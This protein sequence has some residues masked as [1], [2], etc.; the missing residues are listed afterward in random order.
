MS[1][2]RLSDLYA[3]A[4]ALVGAGE[5]SRRTSARTS[6]VGAMR[7]I[8]LVPEFGRVAVGQLHTFDNA[9]FRRSTRDAL[10]GSGIQRFILGL[11]VS[12]NHDDGKT[13]EAHFQ[14][15]WWGFFE[16]PAGNWRDLLKALAN[17]SRIV[18][19]PIKAITPD[20]F[21]AAA[22]YGL[23]STFK[24][25]VSYVEANRRRPDRGK[26]RNTRDRFLRDEAGV[27][28]MLFLDRIGLENRMLGHGLT[29]PYQP[30]RSRKPSASGGDH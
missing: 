21:E 22:A 16:E 9:A 20:S 6:G 5:R 12:L 28:L 10:L 11:D 7:A 18:S 23:K 19:R 27:E 4:A 3:G 24:R 1:K 15:Q 30:L 25:R 26:C 17:P 2:R 13:D 8:S 29:V 14:L